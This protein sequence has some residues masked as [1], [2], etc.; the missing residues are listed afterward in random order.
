M[1]FLRTFIDKNEKHFL[2][3]GKLEKLYYLFEAL[4]G[5][6]YTPGKT[7]RYPS[8][9]RDGMDFKRMMMVVVYI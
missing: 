9:I 2:K 4:D 8:Y 5:F 3:G 1:R 7:T 6:M